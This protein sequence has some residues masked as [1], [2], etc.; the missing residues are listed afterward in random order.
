MILICFLK[1]LLQNSISIY[2][3]TYKSETKIT[4]QKRK[5]LNMRSKETMF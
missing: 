5:Y 1:N 4:V 2:T 3:N